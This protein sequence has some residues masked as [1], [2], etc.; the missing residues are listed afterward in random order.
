M[1]L[2]DQDCWAVQWAAPPPARQAREGPPCQPP[3]CRPPHPAR[4]PIPAPPFKMLNKTVVAVK[5]QP[6]A[7]SAHKTDAAVETWETT[8]VLVYSTVGGVTLCPG[9][10]KAGSVLMLSWAFLLPAIVR[11]LQKRESPGEATVRVSARH[12]CCRWRRCAGWAR[13]PNPDLCQVNK[14]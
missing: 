9:V 3:L 4:H 14:H 8:T 13:P 11:E 6:S 5:G 1:T 2:P 7:Y 10:S 12:C